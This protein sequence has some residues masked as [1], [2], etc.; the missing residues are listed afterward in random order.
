MK[1]FLCV[2]VIAIVVSSLGNAANAGDDILFLPIQEALNQPKAQDVLDP[3]IKLYFAGQ[4]TPNYTEKI[5]TYV[6]NKKGNSTFRSD[7]T[8]C[9][10]VILSALISLQ[11]R[12]IQMGGTAVVDIESFYKKKPYR[13]A[14]K[15]EC[16]AGTIMAGVALRGTIVKK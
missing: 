4:R 12:A 15:F 6:S 13:S 11:Q 9:N 7:E 10:W 8:A 1:Q 5:G 16:H 3:N 14:T 2:V